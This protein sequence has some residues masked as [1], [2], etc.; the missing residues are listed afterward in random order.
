MTFELP[1]KIT[2][3]LLVYFTFSTTSK[4]QFSMME[5]HESKVTMT[6]GETVEGLLMYNFEENLI[7]L[8]R[9]GKILVVPGRKF[10]VAEFRDKRTDGIRHIYSLPFETQV[11]YKV[12]VLFEL[13]IQG[14]VS[15]L[16]R[17]KV[18]QEMGGQGSMYSPSSAIVVDVL[19]HDFYFLTEE[20]KIIY[21]NGTKKHLLKIFEDRKAELKTYL[22]KNF[23]RYDSLGDLAVI[24]VFCN[25]I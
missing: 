22:R 4:A 16:T 20:G 13:Q 21:Y 6:S 8:K 12:P 24:I 3:L 1:V 23:F 15:L 14:E 7:Q 10:S 19:R 11:N 2:S 25:S 9:S 17:E 5:W 18:V